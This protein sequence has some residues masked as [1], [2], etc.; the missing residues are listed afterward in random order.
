MKLISVIVPYYKKKKFILRSIKSILNQTYKKLEIIIIYDDFEK[1]DLSYIKNISKISKKI[2]LIVN[3]KNLGAGISRNIGIKKSN[4]AY[5]GFLDADD[6]WYSN[7]L[8]SQMNFMH[9]QKV[10]FSFTAYH[11][12]NSNGKKIGFRKAKSDLSFK[13]LISSCDI[14]LSTVLAKKKLF[15]DHCKF[16]NLKTKEDYVVWLKLAKKKIILKGL[17]VPLSKWRSIKKSLSSSPIQKIC[18]AYSVYNK[19]MRFNFVKSCYYVIVLSFNYILKKY[20]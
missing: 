19:Y 3:N 13:D 4:G 10:D 18:D 14:G 2:K 15:T 16:P 12:I 1:K 20:L 6:I 7:K 8:A 9:K 17:N 11:V 5:I